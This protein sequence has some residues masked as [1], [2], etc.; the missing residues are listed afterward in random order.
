MNVLVW[1]INNMDWD[2]YLRECLDS[3]LWGFVLLDYYNRKSKHENPSHFIDNILSALPKAKLDPVAFHKVLLCVCVQLL[4]NDFLDIMGKS[5]NI[6]KSLD[7]SLNDKQ[8]K[9]IISHYEDYG[10]QDMF[11]RKLVDSGIL[12]KSDQ[13]KLPGDSITMPKENMNI[14][15]I[16]GKVDI[17]IITIR[18]DEFLAVIKRF[19]N[20]NTVSGGKNL[21]EFSR[22][23]LKPE[24]EF[25]VVITRCIE[26][27]QE[28]AQA[29]THNM[30]EELSPPWIFLVGIAGGLPDNE[31]SL[32][33]VLL[34]SR[35][36]NFAVTTARQDE[37]PQMNISGGDLHTDVEKL[38]SHL[39]AL[40]DSFSD[41]NNIES[42]GLDKPKIKVPKS[43]S[44]KKFYGDSNWKTKVQSSL[45]INFPE[46][47][48]PRNPR[49]WIAPTA[50]SNTMLKDAEL[51]QRWLE[52]GKAIADV[53]MELSG[54]YTAA[55]HSG[56]QNYRILAIRGLSDIVG[57]DRAP[58]WTEY[59]CNTAAS[60]AY[61]LIMSGFIVTLF[62]H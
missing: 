55:R 25:G 40:V 13:A 17:G 48:P 59:A 43:L 56:N 9:T 53:E 20:R 7:K 57:L 51:A 32:G 42:I 41:W 45:K 36:L 18:E 62:E 5:I 26:Q 14:S 49:F 12:T 61:A 58:E 8:L 31:Y 2:R 54:V 16:K 27:G 29:V 50:T 15:D 3:D 46:E 6:I 47:K 10:Q 37:A 60:F 23:S 39:S 30:I 44:A 19:K 33:D 28:K 11:M 4:G 24:K 35:F 38:L 34:A 22:I 1:R 21:Y 52:S